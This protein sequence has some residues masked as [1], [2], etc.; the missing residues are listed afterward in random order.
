[1]PRAAVPLLCLLLAACAA[2]ARG[3]VPAPPPSA[4][5][6]VAVRPAPPPIVQFQ[7]V[8]TRD[9]GATLR[10]DAGTTVLP[11]TGMRLEVLRADTTDLRVRCVHCPGAA[12]GWVERARVL[13]APHSPQAASRMELGEFVL[14]VRAAAAL[15]D[16]DALRPVMARDFVHTLGPL[17]MGLLE[18]FAAWE[19][20]QFRTVDRMPFVLDR[21]V[22]TVAGT[23]VWAAPPEY[24]TDPRFT[25]LRAGFRRGA[26]GWEW[27]FLVRDGT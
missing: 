22:A 20:E 9:A 8:W 11:Y 18:T 17:E 27:I 2:P 21:G 6:I 19:R 14:A 4:A 25:D 23:P 1:M 10:T 3:P 5:P 15:R 24:A 13:H 26:G 16:V 12:E 7:S